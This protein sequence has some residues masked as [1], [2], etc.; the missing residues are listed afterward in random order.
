MDRL[1]ILIAFFVYVNSAEA[2]YTYGGGSPYPP[3]PEGTYIQPTLPGTSSPS[4]DAPGYVYE[5]GTWHPTIPGTSSR[6]Y[7]G[8]G[9]TVMPPDYY[10]PPPNPYYPY[11]Y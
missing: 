11:H 10:T 5:G 2:Q 9:Y 6:S 3:I 4:Y 1:F 7:D 8:P